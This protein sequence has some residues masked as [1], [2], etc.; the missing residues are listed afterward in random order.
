MNKYQ[1][2]ESYILNDLK[3]AQE[4]IEMY[5]DEMYEAAKRIKSL[6]CDIANKDLVITNQEKTIDSLKDKLKKNV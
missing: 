2:Y 1:S 6:E 4:R 3:Q 5:H